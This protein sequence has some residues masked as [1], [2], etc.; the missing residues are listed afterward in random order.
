MEPGA[1]RSWS[2]AKQMCDALDDAR[3]RVAQLEAA[4]RQIHERAEWQTYRGSCE[5]CR[6][7][8]AGLTRIARDAVQSGSREEAKE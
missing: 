5:S 4:L 6:R 8:W 2:G 7:T 3:S 1:E